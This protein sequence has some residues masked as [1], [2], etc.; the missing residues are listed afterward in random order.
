M[1]DQDIQLPIIVD[2]DG[3]LIKSRWCDEALLEIVREGPL[4]L[5]KTS[6]GLH[7]RARPRVADSAR[8]D[9]DAWPE[10]TELISYLTEQSQLGRRIVLATSA[11]EAV[12]SAFTR[13]HLFLGE[14][15]RVTKGSDPAANAEV[16]TRAF[17]RGFIYAGT[18]STDTA[19]W[20]AAAGRLVVGGLDPVRGR[21]RSA[22]ADRTFDR[23]RLGF[24][25]L[26]RA[27]RPHQW[28]K[29]LLVFVPLVLGGRGDELE[30]WL[31]ALIGVLAISFVASAMYLVNDLLDLPSDRR[32]WS[33]KERPIASGDV[34]I[35]RAGASAVGLTLLGG[36]LAISQGPAAFAVVLVYM[37][38]TLCYS[39]YFK[40]VPILDVF[41]LAGLYSLRLWL[42]IVLTGVRLSPWLLVFSIFLFLSLSLAKRHTE[43]L[44]MQAHGMSAA[45][46][47][48]YRCEDA[49]LTL[50]LGVASTMAAV[51]IMILY[52]IEDA[53]PRQQY[54]E[55]Q[56]LWAVPPI[57]FLFLGRLWLLCQRG[58]LDDDPVAFASK[59]RLSLA[60]GGAMA[61]VAVL[62]LVG[63]GLV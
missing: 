42:G 47:R 14:V 38:M 33:K 23:A 50:T 49:P 19:I 25:G 63:T 43:V 10:N 46:G 31:L 41:L 21:P 37:T 29:N 13:K 26:W 11:P 54:A 35:R 12:I 61:V 55:P 1:G 44:R 7:R 17:P 4:Q 32:H 34:S 58:Q 39:L 56:L 20:Q 2:I 15:M 30:A 48:A 53:F 51:L 45:P 24:A 9:V 40:R 52:L 27:L 62:A 57:L 3:G 18:P 36:T 59:D 28:V 6:L 22:G 8:L 60:L 16:L 5:C